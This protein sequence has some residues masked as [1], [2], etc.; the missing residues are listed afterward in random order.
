MADLAGFSLETSIYCGSK[1]AVYRGVRKDGK[2][3][4][5]KTLLHEFPEPD[6]IARF[7]REFELGSSLKHENIVQYLSLE[8]LGFG[9]AIIEEDFGAVSLKEF[10]DSKP[11]DLLNFL[12]IA[13]GIV[14]GLE[15]THRKRIMHK[16]LNPR[17]IVWN[18][19]TRIVKLIDFGLA[20]LL[21]EE[22]QEALSPDRL[23]GT[24]AYISPE[25]TGRMNRLVDYRSDFYSLGV[26]FYEMLCGKP[27]FVYAEALE[28]VHAHIA[29]RPK[30]IFELRPTLP[31]VLSCIVM[32]LLAKN[33][34]DR[35]QSAYG[36]GADLKR[37]LDFIS[38]GRVV[39]EFEPG[40]EDM[41]EQ[42]RISGRLYGRERELKILTD[43]FSRAEKTDKEILL[44]SGY[45]GIGKSSL[46]RELQKP[47]VEKRGY[48]ISGKFDQ[49][50]RSSPYA[51]VIQAFRGLCAGILTESESRMDRWRKR[52]IENV[53]GGY[54]K[55]IELIPEV[56][57]IMCK[58]SPDLDLESDELLMNFHAIFQNFIK[59][60]SDKEHLLV[61]FLDDLQW[62]DGPS[63]ELLE[64][65]ILDSESTFLFIGAYRDH[66]VKPGHSL[67]LMLNRL[68]KNEIRIRELK[69]RPLLQRHLEQLLGDTLFCEKRIKPLAAL[70][71]K[72][73]GGN[74]FFVS[75]FVKR[76]HETNLLTFN[77]GIR[78]WEW[79]MSR[80]E[81]EAITDNVVELMLE[82]L[83]LLPEETQGL[84][85]AGACL[86]NGF[87][88]QILSQLNGFAPTRALRLLWPAFREG[89]LIPGG[90]G[91]AS[92]REV[93]SSTQLPS[94][95]ISAPLRFLHDRVQQASYYLVEDEKK[96]ALHLKIGRILLNKLSSEELEERLFNVLD[97]LNKG[98]FLIIDETERLHLAELNQRAGEKALRAAA[99]STASN[100]FKA[101][102]DL[103]PDHIWTTNHNLAFGVHDKL[104]LCEHYLIRQD[105]ADKLYKYLFSHAKTDTEKAYILSCYLYQRPWH[106]SWENLEGQFREALS[107]CG[108]DFP[109]QD[110]LKGAAERERE[111]LSG[112]FSDSSINTF[113]SPKVQDAKFR[114][115]AKLLNFASNKGYTT[116]NI[117]LFTYCVLKAMNLFHKCGSFENGFRL[118][119]SY[120]QLNIVEGR[121]EKSYIM[122]KK[123]LKAMRSE[124]PDQFTSG[125]LSDLASTI[126]LY[127]DSFSKVYAL[128][129]K[130]TATANEIGLSLGLI[131]SMGNKMFILFAHGRD[132]NSFWD[133]ASDL[134][135]LAK[136]R[137]FPVCEDLCEAYQQLVLILKG[138]GESHFLTEKGLG[139]EAWARIHISNIRAQIHHLRLQADFWMKSTNQALETAIEV[140]P[141]LDLIP[142]YIHVVEHCFLHALLLARS[143]ADSGSPKTLVD[144]DQLL[145]KLDK[146]RNACP[147]NF[148]HKYF[149]VAAERARALRL[150][151]ETIC[152]L[153]NAAISD[154][155]KYGFIQYEGLANKLFGEFWLEKKM[156]RIARSYIVEARYLYQHWGAEGL[157]LALD[158]TFE[159][160][161]H[162]VVPAQGRSSNTVTFDSRLITT[163]SRSDGAS[164][165][166]EAVLKATC[167]IS[168]EINLEKLLAAIMRTM[169]DSAGARRGLMILQKD[170]CLFIQAELDNQKKE[171]LQSLP[172]EQCDGISEAVV[173]YVLRTGENLVLPDSEKSKLFSRDPYLERVGPCSILC[174]PVKYK[175]RTLGVLYLENNLSLQAFTSE[176]LKVLQILLTQAAIS[177]ENAQLYQDT[178]ELNLSLKSMNQALSEEMEVRKKVE[179]K[180]RELNEA[181]EQRVKE[182]TAA[183]ED[184]QKELIEQAHL[185]GMAD[186]ATSVLHNVG[187][188]LNSVITSGQ[189]I[190]TTLGN[191][192]TSS[193]AKAN[194]TLLEIIN[195]S[196]SDPTSKEQRLVHY[197][198]IL[199]DLLMEDQELIKDNITRILHKVEIIR[200]VIMSQEKYVAGGAHTEVFFL[201]GVV[202]DALAILESQLSR[203]SIQIVRRSHVNPEVKAQKAKLVHVLMNIIRNSVTAMRKNNSEDRII[204]I[205]VGVKTASAFV[206]IADRGEGIRQEDLGRVFTH[207]F[208]TWSDSNGFGLHS[209]ANSLVEMKGKI[210]VESK[211]RGKGASFTLELPLA[212]G[213]LSIK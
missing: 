195:R 6:D 127:G 7:Q 91:S 155:S 74:P 24:L 147:E 110:D 103:L 146:Y 15:A 190:D 112:W 167:V 139:S 185:A 206:T 64:A 141:L 106:E 128:Y 150:N 168:S 68:E 17:N 158:R 164:L 203:E 157:V 113:F 71:S 51:A 62:A 192:K 200:N 40:Q 170:G 81:A 160:L 199:G 119:I 72:K 50:R 178:L 70:I 101:A 204:T 38:A 140:S 123:I 159:K 161:L 75:A 174:T 35:Y 111:E 184:A 201:D 202:M 99:I 173:R 37:C 189:L 130:A 61:L 29:R 183:L 182:R 57:Q 153:Y 156:D 89:L 82:K 196:F 193:L 41:P 207:G 125:G 129:D 22:M 105:D 162:G 13:L 14:A 191:S 198:Q 59:S 90:D 166:I 3:V 1:T 2:R 133:Y 138:K 65:V 94:S 209:C 92:F 79:D 85:Q 177:L 45:S 121:F 108:V 23:E 39:G 181:L 205:T 55:L 134:D 28:M 171:L 144:L 76:L 176:R 98:R 154:S 100:L 117:A 109:N 67:Q 180:I 179:Q 194:T 131:T 32:K 114:E 107:F 149:L 8:K 172:L 143:F 58:A 43:V 208:S 49:Y 151:M 116:G 52:I 93:D 66:E 27:P 211:G 47:I 197:Y 63:L 78:Q 18:P 54:T 88:L 42:L 187:N 126:M 102:I 36:L 11:L 10:I 84:L 34:E 135:D 122:G 77:P 19:K 137:N 60:F 30:P 152:D 86:G 26:T 44:V 9:V 120:C 163:G 165:D 213:A 136:S 145:A 87:N 96:A 16:D 69:L 186:I 20:S 25:Q 80:I 95:A 46:I 104:A 169:L 5:V 73:T 4:I 21:G 12:E 148:G 132:L 83:R 48:F 175:D 97:Q 212:S 118:L 33:A 188:V 53:G 31:R 210:K 56:G 142:G 124:K 115:V